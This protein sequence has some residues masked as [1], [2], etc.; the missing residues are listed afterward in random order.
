MA[1]WIVVLTAAL[2]ALLGSGSFVTGL[3]GGALGVGGGIFM[4][5]FLV[6]V[7]GVSAKEAVAVSL[8]CVIGTSAAASFSAA[9]SGGARLDL[10]LLLEPALVVGAVAASSAAARIDDGAVL[11]GFAG[12]LCVVVVLMKARPRVPLE[13]DMAPLGRRRRAALLGAAAASGAA[14]GVFGVG[15]GVLVIPALTLIGRV[16]LKTAAATSSLALMTSAACGG[17]VYV[18]HGLVSPALVGVA[19]VGILPGGV[20]GARLQRRLPERVLMAVFTALMLVVAGGSFW[21]GLQ[22]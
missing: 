2:I 16:P 15:G 14:S 20:L 6:F 10:A 18:A 7:A 4:V 22:S 11:M 3:L 8:C 1:D 9:R 19:L 21:R 13:G 5:P 17:M 12:F